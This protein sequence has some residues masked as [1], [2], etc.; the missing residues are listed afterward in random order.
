MGMVAISPRIASAFFVFYGR[1]G[2]VTLHAQDRDIS[3]Q[4]V[5]READAVAL[6]VDGAAGRARQ[7]ELA[8]QLAAVRQQIAILEERLGQA[9]VIDRDRQAKFASVGQAEGVSLPITRRLLH[10]FLS[11]ATP[12]V[13]T[14]GRRTHQA[15][16]R[17]GTLLAGTDEGTK[18]E[19][20]VFAR[21]FTKDEGTVFARSF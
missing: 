11:K 10:V 15:A 20:T 3:R 1:H 19:G 8:S 6:A 18:D 17:S 4:R 21:S 12:S 2:D 9:V 16:L 14:L 7:E 13:A 5:Y